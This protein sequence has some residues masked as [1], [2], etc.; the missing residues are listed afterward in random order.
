MTAPRRASLVAL[1]AIL[2][3]GLGLATDAS[4]YAASPSHPVGQ[5]SHAV[6][7]SAGPVAH[8]PPRAQLQRIGS[9]PQRNRAARA[10]V[11]IITSDTIAAQ[12][13]SVPAPTK[14]RAPPS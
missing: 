2:L 6:R 11:R 10:W 1:V 7:A 9:L 4:A 5:A 14:S 12:G 13:V 3:V 8:T